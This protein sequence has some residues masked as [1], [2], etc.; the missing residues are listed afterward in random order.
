[1]VSALAQVLAHAEPRRLS[2]D[3]YDKLAEQGFFE[4]ERVELIQGMVVQMSPIGPTH[5]DP[6]DVLTELFVKGVSGRARVRIQQ[7][8]IAGANS[9]PEPDVALVPPGRY[10]SRHPDRAFLIVEVAESSLAHDR[11]TKAQ[12][13]SGSGVLEYWIVDVRGRAV[14]V[15]DEIVD[16]RYARIRAFDEATVLSPGSFPDVSLSVA[17]LFGQR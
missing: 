10:G 2:R 15:H 4:G 7:P 14:H 11:E 5:A 17:E 9:E 16:G 12:L 8:F 1:M 6:V 13:Y 3:E